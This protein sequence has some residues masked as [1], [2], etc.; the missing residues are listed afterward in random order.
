M[1]D[2]LDLLKNLNFKIYAIFSFLNIDRQIYYTYI[3]CICL[4][5]KK[6]YTI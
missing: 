6:M 5:C 2:E 1:Y 3:L 4:F